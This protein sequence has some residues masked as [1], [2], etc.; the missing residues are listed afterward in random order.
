MSNSS[1]MCQKHWS[2]FW[3]MWTRSID[4][5]VLL[6]KFWQICEKMLDDDKPC[7]KPHSVKQWWAALLKIKM[8]NQWS[9]NFPKS[10]PECWMQILFALCHRVLLISSTKLRASTNNGCES[11]SR[12][13]FVWTSNIFSSSLAIHR[14]HSMSPCWVVCWISNE[15]AKSLQAAFNTWWT[16]LRPTISLSK[17][18]EDCWT[19]PRMKKLIK[20]VENPHFIR[21][22]FRVQLYSLQVCCLR[23]LIS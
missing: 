1:W 4:S 21:K 8:R 9:G 10:E 14:I 3:I 12:K 13:L 22:K 19:Y 16:L 7:S 17:N 5:L 23:K 18:L 15:P 20:P 2:L 6:E 11:W